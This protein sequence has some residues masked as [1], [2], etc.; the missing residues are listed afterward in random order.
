MKEGSLRGVV[1]MWVRMTLGVGMLLL[2]FYFKIFGVMGGILAVLISMAVNY[3]M[4]ILIFEAAIHTDGKN[5][6]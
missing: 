6:I 2:P 5:F 1:I 3:W 4:Y